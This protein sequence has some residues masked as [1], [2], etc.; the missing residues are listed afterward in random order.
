M[1]FVFGLLKKLV[2]SISPVLELSRQVFYDA[3][4]Q[5]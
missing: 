4:D 1:K 5:K 2:L 3:Y